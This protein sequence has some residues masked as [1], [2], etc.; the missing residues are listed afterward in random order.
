MKILSFILNF[1]II[2]APVFLA[3]LLLI[4]VAAQHFLRGRKLFV[5]LRLRLLTTKRLIVFLLGAGLLFKLLLS[6]LQYYVWRAS[7]LGQFL[8]PPY[9]SWGYFI[10]YS[11]FHFWL[12]GLLSLI[13]AAALYLIFYLLKR[14]RSEVISAED[15]NLA[16]LL[17]LLAGWPKFVI[18]LPLFLGLTLISVIIRTIA[19]KEA[20]SL[21]W[22]LILAMLLTLLLGNYL[23]ILLGLSALAV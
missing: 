10:R 8:L 4:L 19:K 7:G 5:V 17:A 13:M 21:A 18:F 1:G 2:W 20:A 15:L 23:V 6:G 22:P 12:P 11:F 16:F 3:F 14:R 9:Q